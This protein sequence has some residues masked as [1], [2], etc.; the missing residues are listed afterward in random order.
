MSFRKKKKDSNEIDDDNGKLS[1]SN[2]INESK[3]VEEYEGFNIFGTIK[4]D[5]LFDSSRG[6]LIYILISILFLIFGASYIALSS[7]VKKR[8]EVADAVQE[9]LNDKFNNDGLN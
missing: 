8:N 7:R 4:V 9:E 5:T 1:E 2:E 6:Y 3:G